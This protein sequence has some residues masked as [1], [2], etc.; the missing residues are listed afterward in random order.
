M[1]RCFEVEFEVKAGLAVRTLMPFEFCFEFSVVFNLFESECTRRPKRGKK[2]F[3][4][5]T[6]YISNFI[7][8]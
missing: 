5:V 1:L 4:L 3:V 2:H 8:N 6:L 7:S